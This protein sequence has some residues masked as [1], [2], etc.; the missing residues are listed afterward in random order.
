MTRNPNKYN[1]QG[2][3]WRSRE[4]LNVA[5]KR[6]DR[7]GLSLSQY[8]NILVEKDLNTGGEFVLN[9]GANSNVAE[10]LRQI[11]KEKLDVVESLPRE[12]PSEKVP[13]R[14][15]QPIAAQ[16]HEAGTDSKRKRGKQK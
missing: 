15:L 7:L 14:P 6:A 8:V 10:R 4:F 1:V 9:D 2:I 11:V 3:S 12:G 13:L 5:K 16:T